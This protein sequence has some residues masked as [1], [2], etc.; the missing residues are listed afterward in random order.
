MNRKSHVIR[1]MLILQ[2]SSTPKK[3]CFWQNCE[4]VFNRLELN[5]LHKDRRQ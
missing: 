5:K 4:E 3:L 2:I 1:Y